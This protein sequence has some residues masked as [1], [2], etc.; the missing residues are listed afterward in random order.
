MRVPRKS[1]K[2]RRGSEP[3][4][5]RAQNVN[6]STNP[7]NDPVADKTP[8][9]TRKRISNIMTPIREMSPAASPADKIVRTERDT[10]EVEDEN[11]KEDMVQR[12]QSRGRTGDVGES[13]SGSG[14]QGSGSGSGSGSR[15]GSGSGSEEEGGP[16]GD[17]AQS[18]DE[19]SV[20]LMSDSEESSS[21]NKKKKTIKA[22]YRKKKYSKGKTKKKPKKGTGM[23]R[24][25]IIT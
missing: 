4:R 19:S 24:I 8:V 22:K 17:N 1:V 18:S 13:G 6:E 23:G 20:D 3:M 5:R 12:Q 14:S 11:K 16:L 15:S 9:T 7:S 25:G 21:H 2:S 10:L